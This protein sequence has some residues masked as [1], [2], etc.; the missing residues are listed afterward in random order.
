[1]ID[2]HTGEDVAVHQALL[3]QTLSV[4]LVHFLDF[5]N[6]AI[7]RVVLWMMMRADELDVPDIR[8]A[9]WMLVVTAQSTIHAALLEDPGKLTEPAFEDALVR[10]LTRYIL[11]R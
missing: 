7:D 3:E 11:P 9:A 1:M 5:Q 8:T 4:G 10:M 2:A 6:Q